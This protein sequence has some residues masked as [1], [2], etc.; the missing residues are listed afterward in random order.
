MTSREALALAAI[1]LPALSALVLA[2]A[3]RRSISV[4]ALLGAFASAAAAL[5]LA[6][7]ALAD[8]DSPYV[9][10]WL[11]VDAAA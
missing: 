11:V 3:P 1:G 4:V 7:V 10:D 6:A 9:G 8:P 2:V 5:A